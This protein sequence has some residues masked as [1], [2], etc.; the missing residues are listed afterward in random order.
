[1]GW[2]RRSRARCAQEKNTAFYLREHLKPDLG[3]TRGQSGIFLVSFPAGGNGSWVFFLAR[4]VL[5]SRV[6]AKKTVGCFP[7][8]F[9]CFCAFVFFCL[10]LLGCFFVFRA[11]ARKKNVFRRGNE[12]NREF[13]LCVRWSCATANEAT[14]PSATVAQWPRGMCSNQRPLIQCF[15][16][17][18]E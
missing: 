4:E 1:M 14:W 12:Q 6:S 13:P 8:L 2:Y 5:I 16:C 18:G 17:G 3:H 15:D 9:W 10:F 7:R 11:L